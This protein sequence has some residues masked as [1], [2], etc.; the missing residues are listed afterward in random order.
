MRLCY[1]KKDHLCA[2][3]LATFWEQGLRLQLRFCHVFVM[4]LV[5][6]LGQLL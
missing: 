1:I 2:C 4:W 6:I 3:D 5:A